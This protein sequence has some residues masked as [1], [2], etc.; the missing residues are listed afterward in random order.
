MKSN[1]W[2]VL[3]LLGSMVLPASLSG[4]RRSM[5][6]AGEDRPATDREVVRAQAS[7]KA[8]P[9]KEEARDQEGFRFPADGG[10]VLLAREL[11]PALERSVLNERHPAPKR[12]PA[13][14]LEAPAV[15]L[16]PAI[17]LMPKAPLEAKRPPLQP[18]LVVEESLSSRPVPVL[19]QAQ[20]LATGKRIQLPSV[21]I[22]LPPP[23]PL[24]TPHPLA[25]RAS[26]DDATSDVSTGA[27]LAAT[28]PQRST[29]VPFQRLTIPDPYEN[30]RPVQSDSALPE[31]NQPPVTLPQTPKC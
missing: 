20:T 13:P 6:V 7:D 26:L 19:P 28:L 16:P 30:R 5:S 23:L 4:C 2:P 11:P 31:G 15:P 8:E 17:I 14:S 27:A 3:L 1:R 12:K 9:A 22:D 24:L 10:G 18:R 29:P 25:E 21:D